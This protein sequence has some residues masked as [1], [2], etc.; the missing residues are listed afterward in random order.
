MEVSKLRCGPAQQAAQVHLPSQMR[1]WVGTTVF[2]LANT[3]ILDYLVS[4]IGLVMR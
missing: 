3:R 4:F 1:V 2:L